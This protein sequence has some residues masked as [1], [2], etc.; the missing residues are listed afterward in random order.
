VA[1]G[2]IDADALLSRY[3]TLVY[4]QAGSYEGT[5]RRIGLDR[6]TVRARIDREFLASLER[7][8]ETE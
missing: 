8:G 3:A 1:C 5:A 7:D 2:A 6:R 4:H